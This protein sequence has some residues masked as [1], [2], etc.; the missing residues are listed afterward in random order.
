MRPLLQSA[1]WG[2]IV[3]LVAL[4]AGYARRISGEADRQHEL[5]IDRLGRLSPTPTPC[6]S[7]CTGSP[8]P[9]P[10]SLDLDDVLDTTLSR[11]KSLVAFDS[12][13][14]LLFDETDAHWEVVRRQG[15][16][17]P[18][19]LGPTEL[20]PGLRQAIA[21][22]RPVYVPDLTSSAAGPVGPG[23]V[24]HLRRRCRPA[25]RSSASSPSSTPT[26]T[27]SPPGTSSSSRASSSRPSW[28]STTP[29]GSPGCAPS[30][31]T[32]SAPASPATCTTASASPSPT[33]PSSSTA[34]WNGT[35]SGE[36]VTDELGQ[37]RDDVRGVIR[38]VRDTLYDL[39]TDVSEEQDLGQVLETV[40]R[41]GAGA[42]RARHPGRGGPQRPPAHPPG[43][44]DVADRPGG[45]RQRRAPR[46]GQRRPHRVALRRR[47]GPDRGHRQRQSASRIRHGRAVSTPT[48]S[49][50]CGSGPPASAP[51]SRSS[52][53]QGGEP[54]C[55]AA[56]IPMTRRETPTRAQRPP[57]P[58]P[59]GGNTP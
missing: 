5:A 46:P 40:R 47:A 31:P 41:P 44:R 17:V 21:E 16:H 14:V 56:S 57:R 15:L 23:R 9:C 59:L 24:R 42:Q 35:Q 34:S 39:R 20:P 13:A 11:L 51:P 2:G 12:V 55:A 48:G 7:P 36:G 43:A 18:S 4:I 28:P 1:S 58:S 3:L 10:A 50:A 22:N 25:A 30:A 6:S 29:A 38:E 8:R 45:A 49:W 26:S 32:R 37:L 54:G 33:W 27:T 19:R 52:A 53:H